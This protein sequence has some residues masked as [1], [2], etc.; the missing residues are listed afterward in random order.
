VLEPPLQ[1]AFVRAAGE[2]PPFIR[3]DG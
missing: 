3:A 1:I 2:P